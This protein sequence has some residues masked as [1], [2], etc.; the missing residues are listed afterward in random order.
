MASTTSRRGLRA[1]FNVAESKDGDI[2]VS[3]VDCGRLGGKVGPCFHYA[4]IETAIG[5]APL[6][7]LARRLGLNMNLVEHLGHGDAD[8]H[9]VSRQDRFRQRRQK[10]RSNMRVLEDAQPRHGRESRFIRFLSK[11][12]HEHIP[13]RHRTLHHCTKS[14]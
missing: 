1:A 7:A 12:R 5:E 10:Q 13:D 4:H 3:C 14:V 9:A 11:H 2:G 6:Q 8:A